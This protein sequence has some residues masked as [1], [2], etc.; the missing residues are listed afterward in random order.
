M[1]FAL[2]SGLDGRVGEEPAKL[3]VG[4]IMERN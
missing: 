1:S 4:V 2:G 3:I